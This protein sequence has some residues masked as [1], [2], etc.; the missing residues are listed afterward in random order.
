VTGLLDT[1]TFLW[2]YGDQSRLSATA[3]AFIRD[4]SNQVL[5]SVVTPW[6]MVIKQ[7]TGKL[8][9]REPV[10]RVVT[11]QLAAGLVLLPVTLDHILALQGLPAAHKDPFDR[12]LVAQAIAEGAVLLTDDPVLR[13][14]PVQVVW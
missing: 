12:L 6:E 7:G 2:L 3:L 4:P 13:Q 14:Y 1:H 10:G 8:I 9:L 5:V 11:T